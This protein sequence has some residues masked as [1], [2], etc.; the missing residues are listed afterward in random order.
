MLEVVLHP[1]ENTNRDEDVDLR[2]K[3]GMAKEESSIRMCGR[4]C[5]EV[6]GLVEGNDD[7]GVWLWRRH[8]VDI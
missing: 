5:V 1:S 6:T 8:M 4:V 3:R 2:V 7:S